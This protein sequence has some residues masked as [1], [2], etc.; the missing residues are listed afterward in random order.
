MLVPG[1]TDSRESLE[2]L[3]DFIRKLKS[4]ERV[5]ILPYHTMGVH[6]WESSWN[7]LLLKKCSAAYGRRSKTCRRDFKNQISQFT[8]NE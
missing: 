2:A 7:S 6:K 4:V 3:Y 8:A 1:L 5:E